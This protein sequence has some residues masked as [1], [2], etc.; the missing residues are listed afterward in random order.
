MAHFKLKVGLGLF[1]TVFFI[2][3]CWL[4]IWQLHRY[5]YKKQLLS[6]YQNRLTVT[7]KGEYLN[8]L[9]ILLQ[10]QFYQGQVGFDVLTPLKIKGE[11]KLLL[12]DRG[13]IKANPDQTAPTIN[14]VTGEQSLKGYIKLM[15]ERSFILGKN[16]LNP[17][18]SPLMI[19]RL[20]FDELSHVMHQSFY[21]DVL[22]LNASEPNGFLRN[23]VVTTILPERHM[24]YA[25]QWFAMAF[26]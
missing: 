4:G 18:T 15:N 17:L 2:L 11:K 8:A 13:W 23:W 26:V 3:F 22:R 25:V 9:T 1:C 7:V 14:P 10:N 5:T 24:A 19:Q 16:I 20:D 12:V 6:T 21:P